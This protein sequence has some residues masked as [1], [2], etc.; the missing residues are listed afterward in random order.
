MTKRNLEK[1][2]YFVIIKTRRY[3]GYFIFG[4]QLSKLLCSSSFYFV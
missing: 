1:K 4:K 2:L 3:F